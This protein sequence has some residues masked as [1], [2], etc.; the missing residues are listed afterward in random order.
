LDFRTG[1]EIMI[2]DLYFCYRIEKE[3]GLGDDEN[4]NPCEVYAQIE[5]GE[6]NTE[7]RDYELEKRTHIEGIQVIADMFGVKPEYIIPI[8]QEEYDANNGENEED[9]FIGEA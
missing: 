2:Y 6:C 5:L 3:A 9:K 4:G 7:N 8:S 1:G